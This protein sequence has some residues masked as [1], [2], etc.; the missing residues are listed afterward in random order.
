MDV[1][2]P[3][4]IHEARES[5]GRALGLAHTDTLW[6]LYRALAPS[7]S[8]R[9]DRQEI[10]RRRLRNAVL[11]FLAW[12]G[13]DEAI[14]AAWSQ[15]ENADNM[16]DAQAA[17]LVLADQDHPRRDDVIRD[18]YERWRSDPLVLDKWF[19]IQAGSR[20]RDTLDRVRELAG[21]PD[22]KLGNPN[23]VRSLV[24]AFCSGNPVRFH[25]P[26]GDGYVFL[27]DHVLALDG[28]NPQ[29]ASRL[30]SIFN[31]WRRYDADRQDRMQAQLDRIA[32]RGS[33]S[34]DVYEIVSRALSR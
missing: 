34:K 13:Q 10:D 32:S 8:Y 22:F 18:F 16:T 6:A 3:D 25:D 30:V 23:R 15:Y 11:R 4:A 26:S 27:A 31:D 24:A 20:R 33:L 1:I 28:A 17:F 7:G 21:H 9:L 12:T 19:A 29:L 14:E 2:R 5:L